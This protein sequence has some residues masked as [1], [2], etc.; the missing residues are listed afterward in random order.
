MKE[1]FLIEAVWYP[2]EQPSVVSD[3]IPQGRTVLAMVLATSGS[4]Y[5]KVGAC[6]LVSSSRVLSGMVSGGCLEADL[7]SHCASLLQGETAGWLPLRYDT[8][9][10][11]DDVFGSALGCRG[12]LDLALIPCL[13]PRIAAFFSKAWGAYEPWTGTGE[14]QDDGGLRLSLE[15]LSR[16]VSGMG[17]SLGWLGC[18]APQEPIPPLAPLVLP[19]LRE[20]TQQPVAPDNRAGACAH[21]DS[22]CVSLITVPKRRRIL[23][24]GC[25]PD[26]APLLNLLATCGFEVTAVDHRPDQLEALA[27]WLDAVR[28]LEP[29]TDVDIMLDAGV[30]LSRVVTLA[31]ATRFL[32]E[33]SARERGDPLCATEPI[34]ILCSPVYGAL[35]MSHHLDWD[36]RYLDA[37]R[38]VDPLRCYVGLL[39]PPARRREVFARLP[40]DHPLDCESLRSP[41][42]LPLKARG[43]A[44]VAVAVVADL[45]GS[46]DLTVASATRAQPDERRSE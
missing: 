27:L 44:A 14:L 34:P 20:P 10:D 5:Q 39:G 29:P 15:P 46:P 18:A 2:S 19:R 38:P 43:P 12:C 35:V 23:V 30:P 37:L 7:A 8:R 25:G 22:G 13:D 28:I 32:A 41:M 4:T 36:A 17:S 26:A 45:L 42:G 33:S 11:D 6:A 21:G 40:K 31:P 9:G 3:P 16:E 1:T 24:L